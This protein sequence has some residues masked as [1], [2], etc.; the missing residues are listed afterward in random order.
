MVAASCSNTK[1][2][3]AGET[4]FIGSKINI[5]DHEASK[6]RTCNADKADLEGAVRPRPRLQNA[7]YEAEAEGV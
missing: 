7:G 4:L 1:H 2:L 5:K 3:P 6:E